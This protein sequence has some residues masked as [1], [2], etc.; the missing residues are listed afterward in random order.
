MEKKK[1]TR[2]QLERRI[3]NAIVFIPKTKA[4]QS[5]YFSDKGLRVI[6]DDSFAIIETGG[7]RHVFS[8]V[9]LT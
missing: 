3:R 6:V 9:L 4:T 7:H 2:D 8:S 1:E 5:I